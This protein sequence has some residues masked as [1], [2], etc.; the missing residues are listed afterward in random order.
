MI[1]TRY[2]LDISFKKTEYKVVK[3]CIRKLDALNNETID[4]KVPYIS[5]ENES[6][7]E[8]N[9][10]ANTERSGPELCSHWPKSEFID[11]ILYVKYQL[12]RKLSPFGSNY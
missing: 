1:I 6:K 11:T 7:S 3:E 2:L 4:D 8:V 9:I 10:K 5:I 12:I